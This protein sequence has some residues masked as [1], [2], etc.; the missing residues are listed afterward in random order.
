MKA[1]REWLLRFRLNFAL[2]QGIIS[3]TFS[4]NWVNG[5]LFMF[6][7]RLNK[8]GGN[9]LNP[10]YCKDIAYYDRVT[11]NFYYRSSPYSSSV[12][13][14]VGSVTPSKTSINVRNLMY[15][16]TIINLGVKNRLERTFNDFST[17][18]YVVNALNT[19]SH[20]DNSDLLNLFIVSRILDSEVWMKSLANNTLVNSFFSRLGKKVDGDLAQILSIN[21]EFGVVKFSPEIYAFTEV[22]SPT[23]VFRENN[24]NFIGVFYSSSQADLQLKDHITP[25]RVNFRQGDALVIQNYGNN[26]Q[27][28]PF[29]SWM[30]AK[31]TK[32]IFGNDENDWGTNQSN[33]ISKRYQSL[34]RIKP[35]TN[36]ENYTTTDYFSD[37]SFDLSYNNDRGYIFAEK[38]NK[39]YKESAKSDSFVVGAPFH[40]YFGIKKGFSALDKFKTKYLNE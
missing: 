19:T 7:F 36:I 6:S 35:N 15:P 17:F 4:N 13:K 28:V 23:I 30:L 33:I 27:E 26:S 29:Y 1:F 34:E 25:G 11:N 8:F 20:Y 24:K 22:N 3:E 9:Q 12:K 32:T 40:F 16:T 14:F 21:S 38:D 2:C 10:I 18:G 31:K 39:Y 5:S 37:L